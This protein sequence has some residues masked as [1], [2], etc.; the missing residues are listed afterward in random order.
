MERKSYKM[1]QAVIFDLDGVIV[2]SEPLHKEAWKRIF[3]EEGIELNEEDLKDSIGTTNH[4][5]LKKVLAEKNLK[6]DFKEWYKRKA[7][8]YKVLLRKKSRSFPGVSAL[9]KKLNR[10]YL[11]AIASSS[12][13]ENI[14]FVLNKLA[15][16]GYFKIIIGRENVENHKPHPEIYLLAAEKLNVPPERSIV[17]EDS[18]VGVEAAKTAGMRCIAVCNSYPQE[19]LKKADLVV[20]S[21][22][23]AEITRFIDNAFKRN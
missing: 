14:N 20:N 11:L 1:K 2:D 17:I 12:W 9:I 22:K 6:V 13:R 4:I 19:R 10:K 8:E 21:L 15:L 23:E 3:K 5:L 18:V 16:K 7:E